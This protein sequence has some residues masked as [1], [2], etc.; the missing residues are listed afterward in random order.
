MIINEIEKV[1]K[2]AIKQITK[3][4][5][6]WLSEKSGWITESVN[7]HYLNIAKYNPMKGSSHIQFSKELRNPLKSLVNMKNKDNESFR[8]CHIRHLNPQIKIHIHKVSRSW[9]KHLLI[10]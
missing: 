6:Q 3:K 5:A 2:L 8:W 10:N 4:I 7:K 9:I 1:L